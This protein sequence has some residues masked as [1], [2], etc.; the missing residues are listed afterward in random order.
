[1]TNN[2]VLGFLDE[3]Q[4]L[5]DF[6]AHRNLLGNLDNGIFQTEVAGVDNAV[7]IGNVAQNAVA[8]IYMLQ[9]HGVD[10]IVRS[11]IAT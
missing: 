9:H 11:R 8:H 10:T 1:M 4:N 2:S 3:F 7:G 6:F 5:F